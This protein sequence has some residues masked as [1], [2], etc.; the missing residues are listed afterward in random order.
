MCSQLVW[1]KDTGLYQIWAAEK[2][3][4]SPECTHW[5]WKEVALVMQTIPDCVLDGNVNKKMELR[6]FR[7]KT[8]IFSDGSIQ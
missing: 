7:S 5:D 3:R 4:E 8:D 6:L 1:G 2:V